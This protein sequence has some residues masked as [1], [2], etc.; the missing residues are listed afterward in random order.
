MKRKLVRVS[1][2]VSLILLLYL[3]P[4]SVQAAEDN[5]SGSF[6][7][8][9]TSPTVNSVVLYDTGGTPA[10]ATTMDPLVEY[11]VRV[12]VTDSNTLDDL[13][14]LT[15]TIYYDA[16]GT[17]SAAQVPGTGDTQTA[18]ILTWTTP[19]TWAI[20]GVSGG[21]SW[22]INSGSCVAPTLTNSSGTFQFVFTPGKVATE[23]PGADEC[24][25]SQCPSR[26]VH[27]ATNRQQTRN[28]HLSC[29][30]FVG[31]HPD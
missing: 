7:T 19:S 23:T 4:M 5:S 20:D 3:I 29:Y 30:P 27:C 8:E 22:S 11:D 21:G 25:R 28:T 1:I 17:Y 2:A 14:T 13:D 15:V 12:D 26:R 6:Q 24:G 18:A 16:D 31:H 9:G 10:P